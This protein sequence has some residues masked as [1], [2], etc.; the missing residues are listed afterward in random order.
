MD[1]IVNQCIDLCIEEFNKN[2]NKEKLENEI[3]D[4]VI[5]YIG[6][7]L[8]PY[9]LYLMIFIFILL[10]LLVYILYIVRKKNV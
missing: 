9:I 4:P 3:L 7:R 6:N 10:T 1:T 2:E 8:W 5:K